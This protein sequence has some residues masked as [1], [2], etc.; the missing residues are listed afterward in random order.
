M[1]ILEESGTAGLDGEIVCPLCEGQGM[2]I[3]EDAHGRRSA[4][5]CACRVQQRA[6]RRL[7]RA[8][9]PR[10]YEHCTLESFEYSYSGAD[11]S[12]WRAYK[13]AQKFIKGYHEPLSVEGVGLL[14]VGPPGRG[15]THLAVAVL[16]ALIM[17]R[18]ATGIFYEYG[19]LLRTV[20]STYTQGASVSELDI[21]RPV[22]EAEV[23]VL[24]ELG[25]LRTSEWVSDTVAYLL[26]TRYNDKRTTI[27]T[28]NFPNQA[29][30]GIREAGQ[31]KDV[32]RAVRQETLGDRITERL[33]SRLAEM[34]VEVQIAGDDFRR[35]NP[36]RLE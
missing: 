24:D 7:G 20:Q 17:E 16:Q 2:R 19:A 4:T 18:G 21:L 26:N 25:N 8:R 12:L 30:L 34:C 3:V 27:I 28:T 13:T 36:A 1:D 10:R 31:I 14:L 35:I 6:R 29:P 22:F 32:H 9:I 33:W 15:K 5:P 11:P 23:L